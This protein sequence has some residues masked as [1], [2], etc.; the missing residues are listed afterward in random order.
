MSSTRSVAETA[1]A[2]KQFPE[3]YVTGQIKM[4]RNFIDEIIV[5]GSVRNIATSTV[6][7]DVVLRVNYLSKSG[8]V[9]YTKDYPICETLEP[10]VP[11]KFKFKNPSS[12][13]V[14]RVSAKI[15]KAQ[16]AE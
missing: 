2:E 11:A 12:Q 8:A 3:E 16:P 5:E 1:A 4:R 13:Q 10:N 14:D 6:Y 15:L 9:L 7:K